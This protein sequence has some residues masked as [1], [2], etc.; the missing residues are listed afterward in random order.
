MAVAGN[1]ISGVQGDVLI[2]SNQVR[3]VKKWSFK[4]KMTTKD[5]ASNI[6]AGYRKRVSSTKDGTGTLD[7][8]WDPWNPITDVMDIGA[9]VTLKLQHHTNQF[10]LIPAIINDMSFDVDMDTGDVE[11]WTASFE[12]DG[13]WTKPVAL[14]TTVSSLMA[15]RRNAPAQPLDLEPEDATEMDAPAPT[16]RP[17]PAEHAP[18]TGLSPADLEAIVSQVSALLLAQ[19]KGGGSAQAL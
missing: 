19:L 4:P 10:W 12:T 7:G 16:L 1:G 6:T 15:G 13:Q 18:A 14:P 11:A 17:S 2:G 3:E 9:S 5:Y 8:V